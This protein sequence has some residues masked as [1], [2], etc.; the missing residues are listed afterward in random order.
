NRLPHKTSFENAAASGLLIIRGADTTSRLNEAI[1]L[2]EVV[3]QNEHLL[4]NYGVRFL[5]LERRDSGRYNLV[6]S[7]GRV[8]EWGYP[9]TGRSIS[10][11]TV[12]EKM[13]NLVMVLKNPFAR[14]SKRSVLWSRAAVNSEQGLPRE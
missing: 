8:F 7:D 13:E 2:C 4:S 3:Y 12:K 6:S 11:L 9:P 5:F 1:S 10:Y 14:N